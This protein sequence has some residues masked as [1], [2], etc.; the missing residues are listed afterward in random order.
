MTKPKNFVYM[1]AMGP[2]KGLHLVLRMWPEIRIRFKNSILNIIGGDLYQE[3]VL[4][5]YK[6]LP[7]SGSYAKKLYNELSKMNKADRDSIN[8]LGLL[9][10]ERMDEV[11]R[12]SDVALL[13]PTGKSEAAPAS[14]LECYAYGIPV[15]AGGD[16]GA[17]DNMKYFP[18][19]DLVKNNIDDIINCLDDKKTYRELRIEALELSK[20]LY[21]ENQ[22]HLKD[23][24]NLFNNRLPI[25]TPNLPKYIHRRIWARSIFDL[26]IKRPIKRIIAT[27]I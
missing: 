14:P 17:F 15:V 22:E 5:S 19:L 4:G 24:V 21:S 8:F 20:K 26:I 25:S 1:G 6:G 9:S 27:W 11:L 7:I 12:E 13:N 23:W 16:F 2:A 10:S 18:Q 3:R